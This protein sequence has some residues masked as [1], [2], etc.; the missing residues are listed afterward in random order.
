MNQID[1]NIA[2][3]RANTPTGARNKYHSF[4]YDDESQLVLCWF[5]TAFRTSDY[6]DVDVCEDIDSFTL[7]EW[8]QFCWFD[9]YMDY[10]ESTSKAT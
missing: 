8:Y 5:R 4:K 1:K 7:D 10:L 2:L 9:D 6:W 3:L